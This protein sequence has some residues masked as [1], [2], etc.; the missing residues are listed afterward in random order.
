MLLFD[1][2]ALI[3]EQCDLTTLLVLRPVCR[4]FRHAADFRIC[5]TSNLPMPEQE[6]Q[7]TGHGS[8]SR[9][10]LSTSKNDDG[11]ERGKSITLEEGWSD[12][13]TTLEAAMGRAL[14]YA[15]PGGQVSWAEYDEEKAWELMME[16]RWVD[17]EDFAN[18]CEG[19]DESESEIGWRVMLEEFTTCCS[20]RDA[21]QVVRD[22]GDDDFVDNAYSA[23]EDTDDDSMKHDGDGEA[24]DDVFVAILRRVW[25]LLLEPPQR[26]VYVRISHDYRHTDLPSGG[27]DTYVFIRTSQGK[28]YQLHVSRDYQVL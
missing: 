24:K 17:V 6:Y 20:R 25:G 18:D 3:C 5:I 28:D 13:L 26:L 12:D 11:Y 1:N 27:S 14:S 19:E 23:D 15:D 9:R 16:K 4:P 7:N 2:A 10:E 21:L 8:F 22:Y